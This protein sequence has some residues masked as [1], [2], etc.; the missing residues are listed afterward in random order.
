MVLLLL[1]SS[2]TTFARPLLGTTPFLSRMSRKTS[3]SSARTDKVR[4]NCQTSAETLI[5]IVKEPTDYREVIVLMKEKITDSYDDQEQ[6]HLSAMCWRKGWA[7]WGAADPE[8]EA[9]SARVMMHSQATRKQHYLEGAEQE[10]V[11]MGKKVT[12]RILEES[13]EEE[14]EE[15]S[16]SD[17]GARKVLPLP[18]AKRKGGK[19]IPA[20]RR[21]E[22]SSSEEGGDESD[23]DDESKSD[24]SSQ[25]ALK[26]IS[27]GTS[28]WKPFTSKERA[29]VLT[30]L[31]P[32]NKQPKKL[33]IKAATK[34][35]GRVFVVAMNKFQQ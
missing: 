28:H 5:F 10:L 13:E 34:K 16:G 6:T 19:E 18:P 32:G 21:K 33:E 14:E 26:E 11:Q 1:A 35:S 20:K 8:L 22:Q 12:K 23:S 15:D 7:N 25:S 17:S 29:L 27:T 24:E 4:D 2:S 30:T 3:L 9:I 31:C